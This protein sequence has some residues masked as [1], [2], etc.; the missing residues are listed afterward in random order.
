MRICRLKNPKD[1]DWVSGKYLMQGKLKVEQIKN[2]KV[3]LLQ[4]LGWTAYSSTEFIGCSML[5]EYIKINGPGQLFVENLS[6]FS[7]NNTK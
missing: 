3:L 5:E 7:S 4:L 2:S 6:L 1:I